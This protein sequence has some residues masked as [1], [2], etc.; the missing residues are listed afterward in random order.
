MNRDA[1]RL[2]A[3]VPMLLALV[4]G[5]LALAAYVKLVR[6]TELAEPGVIPSAY[7]RPAALFELAAAVWLMAG[8]RPQLTVSILMILFLGF[9]LF[10]SYAVLV[11]LP[12]CGCFGA[13]RLTPAIIFSI[14]VILLVAIHTAGSQLNHRLYFATLSYVVMIAAIVTLVAFL[15][16]L[17]VSIAST[18]HLPVS[19]AIVTTMILVTSISVSFV[20]QAKSWRAGNDRSIYRENVRF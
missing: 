4:A 19:S 17:V 8:I 5:L 13:V 10:A 6:P 1:D 11:D 14:D 20:R 2:Q 3:L 7:M 18:A 12:S 9:A 16:Y 15:S